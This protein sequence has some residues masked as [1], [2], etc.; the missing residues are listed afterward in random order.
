MT[1]YAQGKFNFGAFS[2]FVS[3]KS[4]NN[5]YLEIAFKGNGLPYS[6]EKMIRDLLKKQVHR[7]KVEVQIDVIPGEGQKWDVQ[8]N[9]ALLGEVVE[10]ILGA[11]KKHRR[12]VTFSLD[13]LLKSP[14][15]LHLDGGNGRL[16]DEDLQK[17]RNSSEQV[18]REFLRN[19]EL[20]GKAILDDLLPSIDLIETSLVALNRCQD[21]IE[22]ELLDQYRKKLQKFLTP[23]FA[24]EKRILMEAAVMAEKSSLTEEINRL[25]T[26]VHRLKTMVQEP[27]TPTL[28]REA[29]FLSQ[30]MQRETHTISAKSGSSEIHQQILVVRREI[31]KIRQQ[32]QNIE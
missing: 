28:G 1:A 6:C 27:D 26:H 18:F 10:K 4:Y 7:G 11:V 13:F 22:A 25:G 2:L 23:E 29:D 15:I 8:I 12:R 19:R 20:E 17:I 24:D 30:E 9:E 21:Q 3:F 32:V 31:E 14:N 5:R 16:N